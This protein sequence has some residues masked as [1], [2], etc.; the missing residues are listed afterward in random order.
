MGIRLAV[1]DSR[2]LVRFG[3]REL[4]AGQ[5]DMDIVLECTSAEEARRG[6]ATFA[7]DVVVV[8]LLLPDG[9]GMA[10]ARALR[11]GRPGL[12]AVVLARSAQDDLFR[13]LEAGVSAFVTHTAPV[14]EVLAAVRHAATAPALFMAVG[15]ARAV[16]DRHAVRDRLSLSRRETDVLLLLRDGLSVAEIGASLFISLSTAKTYVSRIYE[17]LGATTRAQALMTAIHHGLIPYAESPARILGRPG[18]VR[19]SRGPSAA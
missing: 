13:A 2:T 1:I 15:L 8:D 4:V 16:A 12:G 5:P 11:A 7:P 9:D 17:K 18:R 10:V 3:M 19:V 14:E 6:V